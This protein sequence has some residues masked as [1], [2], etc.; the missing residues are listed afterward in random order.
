[1]AKKLSTWFGVIFLL[2]G[3]LG[4]I[5]GITND[6]GMLLGIFHVDAIHNIIHIVFGLLAFWMSMSGEMGAKNYFKVVGIVFGLIAILGFFQ[7]DSEMLIGLFNNNMADTWLHI[8]MAV[9]ALYVGFSGAGSTD[10]S[11]MQPKPP[12][13]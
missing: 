12:A 9:I 6:Q 1:M 13:M 11:S 2:L 7:G 3:V 10:S 4:F 8:V 5:P